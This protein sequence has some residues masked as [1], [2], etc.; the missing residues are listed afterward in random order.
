M[1]SL[2][3]L[4]LVFKGRNGGIEGLSNPLKGT[5]LASTELERKSLQLQSPCSHPIYHAVSL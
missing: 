3:L 2:L 4:T 5:Q 1:R